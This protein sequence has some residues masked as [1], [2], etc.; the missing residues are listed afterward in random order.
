MEAQQR[1]DLWYA[2]NSPSDFV[3][4]WRNIL[5]TLFFGAKDLEKDYATI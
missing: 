1:E 2:M 4:R 3:L 5:F